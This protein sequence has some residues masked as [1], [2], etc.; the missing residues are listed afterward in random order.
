MINDSNQ[1]K[2]DVTSTALEK[3]I[4][5]AK[6]FIDKLVLPPAEELG[7]LIKDQISLWRFN[8]QVRI[9]NKAKVVCEKNNVSVKAIPPK[10]L[11]P[12]LEHASLED[13][14]EL[15][16][17]WAILLVNMVDSQQN[18]QNHVF[19]YILS[20]L[21]SD[22]FKL[23]ESV[24]IEKERRVSELE[25]ELSEF[26][27]NRSA[28][29]IKLKSEVDEISQKLQI[30]SPDGKQVYSA[31]A[32]ELRSSARSKEREIRSLEY[33]EFMF[34]RQ[35]AAPESIPEKNIKEFEIANI[36][37]LGLAK[38]VY[39]ASA[40]T[41]S[42]EVPIGDRDSSYASVDFDIEIDTDTSTI[43]TELGELF[44]DACREKNA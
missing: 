28:I 37:R 1:R 4:D 36:I 33:K 38:V 29:E 9:L 7:L 16:D 39:E 27:K 2:I 43:L 19:P 26:L 44:I 5:V 6:G 3:G 41:H 13:D 8:N 15:Q 14:D 31:E 20:Q 11:C 12:Y 35:I 30:L 34:R 10:L 42:I 21:S 22:E 18:I 24:L 17:K 25:G 23:L 32:M 40:G